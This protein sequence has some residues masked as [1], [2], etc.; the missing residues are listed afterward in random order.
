MSPELEVLRENVVDEGGRRKEDDG[1]WT[2]EVGW[3]V[4]YQ[5]YD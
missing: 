3:L 1:G 5:A 4:G 2:R